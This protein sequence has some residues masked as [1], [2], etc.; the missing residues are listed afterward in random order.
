MNEA[1]SSGNSRGMCKPTYSKSRKYLDKAFEILLDLSEIESNPFLV[2]EI[3]EL[4]TDV[5]CGEYKLNRRSDRIE[6]SNDLWDLYKS[7][8]NKSMENTYVESSL[9]LTILDLGDFFGC[10]LNPLSEK[11]NCHYLLP[12]EKRTRRII[13]SR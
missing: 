2:E 7:I 10:K 3:G 12:P 6:L 9:Y 5:K 1:N 4:K 13:T 11:S 8:E